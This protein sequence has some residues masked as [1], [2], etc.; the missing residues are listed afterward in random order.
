MYEQF[1][2]R[3]QIELVQEV[4]GLLESQDDPT[5]NSR[6]HEL[7]LVRLWHSL[8]EA[9]A[10]LLLTGLTGSECLN[11]GSITQFH[12]DA[13][14]E[15]C[16]L[17]IDEIL[18]KD[19]KYLQRLNEHAD[20][21]AP[22]LKADIFESEAEKKEIVA[23]VNAKIAVNMHYYG[24]T[25]EELKAG[26]DCPALMQCTEDAVQ[27]VLGPFLLEMYEALPRDPQ[28]ERFARIDALF[29]FNQELKKN[30]EL[31]DILLEEMDSQQAF[32][33]GAAS[34]D[35]EGWGSKHPLR[36]KISR[37]QAPRKK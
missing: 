32:F 29:R 19:P 6:E 16:R 15:E 23:R 13:I 2:K 20:E 31:R 18:R 33:Y 10:D 30:P 22:L 35:S 34:L 37:K 12:N 25:D 27:Q 8:T 36:K 3:D 5:T 28:E 11:L 7:E 9:E 26:A 21:L 4:R 1:K 14:E 24:P 17:R